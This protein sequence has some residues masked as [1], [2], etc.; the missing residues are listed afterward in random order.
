MAI[1]KAAII[2]AIFLILTINADSH[3]GRTNADGCHVCRTNCEQYGLE[4]DEYHCHNK[5]SSNQENSTSTSTSSSTIKT[6]S[7]STSKKAT[8]TIKKQATKATSST[9]EEI[10]G[11]AIAEITINNAEQS[12]GEMQNLETEKDIYHNER[13]TLATYESDDYKA[14]RLALYFFSFILILVLV[15]FMIRK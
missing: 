8:T 5:S 11:N 9:L 4:Q 12:D 1:Y 2:L 6:S 10:T 15:T 13:V 14:R 3:P 7:T